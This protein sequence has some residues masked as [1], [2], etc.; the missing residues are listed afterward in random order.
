MVHT[1]F[2]SAHAD[3]NTIVQETGMDE[4]ARD[5]FLARFREDNMDA[6]VGFV[7]MG[8]IFGEGIDLAGERLTGA[9]IVG[10][11]LP[12]ICLERDL[13]REYFETHRRSGFDFAYRL[14]GFNRVLQA[15]GRVI[16]SSRD[17]GVVLLLDQRYAGRRYRELFPFEWAPVPL[18]P[19]RRVGVVVRDFDRTPSFRPGIAVRPPKL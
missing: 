18:G 4:S 9:V 8:G 2:Q 13:I 16:R 6:L 10:V 14:P 12:G 17:R 19:G 1:Q 3:L 5:A 15:A 7:V 11:G